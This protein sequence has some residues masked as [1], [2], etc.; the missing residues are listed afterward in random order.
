MVLTMMRGYFPSEDEEYMSK[1]QVEF[2]R[3]RLM[4]WRLEVQHAAN[5]FLETLKETSMR[6]PDDIDASVTQVDFS[7]D[8]HARVRG[9]R[10]LAQIDHALLRMEE[11]EYGYCEIT[12][13]EIGL[14][15]L[16]A[17]PVATMC[18]EA[19]E[20]LE[21]LACDSGRVASVGLM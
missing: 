3:E 21:R 10:L 2:F 5:S 7:L 19:Q 15:R 6:S 12:G 17:R 11:G 14:R 20:Q 8:V 13:E 1:R 18:V 4:A 9:Q 16:L